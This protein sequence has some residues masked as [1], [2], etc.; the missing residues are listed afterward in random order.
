MTQLAR[1]QSDVAVSGWTP[2]PVAERL[3]EPTPDETTY[4]TSSNPTG[5]TFE[6]QF[7]PLAWPWPGAHKLTVFLRKTDAGNIPVTVA[8]LQGSTLIAFTTVQPSE[9]FA[10]AVLTLTAAE[11]G[12]ITDYTN[13]RLR[14][15]AGGV[16]TDCCPQPIPTLL[17]LTFTSDDCPCIHGLSGILTHVPQSNPPAW[18]AAVGPECDTGEVNEWTLT[19]S[20]GSWVLSAAT[21]V[22]VQGIP[23]LGPDAQSCHP[24]ELVWHTCIGADRPECCAYGLPVTLTI[25]D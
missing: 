18:F 15:I 6:V 25:T 16:P 21:T 17:R 4:V 2:T 14:V 5:D 24:L 9:S 1:P 19:C 7:P 10:S 23:S 13:L 20:S 8:L 3:R 22:C 11:V 12:R